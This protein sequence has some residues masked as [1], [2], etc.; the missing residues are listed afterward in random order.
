MTGQVALGKG[1]GAFR[2]KVLWGIA[3]GIAALLLVY[4]LVGRIA[5]V[6]SRSPT[7]VVEG[8]APSHC[9]QFIAIAKAAYGND[10][11]VRLDP[12]DT[13]CESEIRDEWERQWLPREVNVE[14]LTPIPTLQPVAPPETSAQAPAPATYCLNVISLA[15]AR[16]G[17]DWRAKLD[18]AEAQAC[19][20]EIG[21][22]Q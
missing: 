21:P 6:L 2:P 15:K 12:R 11:K 13:T 8:L 14:T 1:A 4:L 9:A 20:G 22:G 19:G 7:T 5:N 16:Y 17:A 3:A 18:P 10:W